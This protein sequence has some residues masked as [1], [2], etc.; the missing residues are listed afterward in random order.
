MGA[1]MAG[2]LLWNWAESLDALNR[3]PALPI[4]K[5]QAGHR[6]RE[7]GIGKVDAIEQDAPGGRWYSTG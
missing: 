5:F 4:S 6:D 3:I 7:N 2:A 1:F